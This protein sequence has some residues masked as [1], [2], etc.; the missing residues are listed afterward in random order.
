MMIVV[1]AIV[2]VIIVIVVAILVV[3]QT[4]E[5]AI[6]FFLPVRSVPHQGCVEEH[7]MKENAQIADQSD[8]PHDQDGQPRCPRCDDPLSW[9]R[10]EPIIMPTKMM[11]QGI[12]HHSE[13]VV[14]VVHS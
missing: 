1:V 2:V 10:N 4:K 7:G 13:A 12:H 6:Q 5:I 14:V 8:G 3:F 11:Y 9:W